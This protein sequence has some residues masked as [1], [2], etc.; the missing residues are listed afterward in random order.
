[1]KPQHVL[2]GILRSRGGV[3]EF[4][5]SYVRLQLLSHG[6]VVGRFCEESLVGVLMST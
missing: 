5:L 4:V 2:S 3:R 6:V 1:M